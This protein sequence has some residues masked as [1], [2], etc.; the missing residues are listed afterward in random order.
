MGA[1]DLLRTSKLFFYKQHLPSTMMPKERII[2]TDIE[3]MIK[4][5]MNKD[6]SSEAVQTIWDMLYNSPVDIDGPAFDACAYCDEVSN[7]FVKA[8]KVPGAPTD[9]CNMLD[10]AVGAYLYAQQQMRVALRTAG[11]VY[12]ECKRLLNQRQ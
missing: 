11:E 3:R 7:L 8:L 9:L 2:S 12:D 1:H 5:K 10:E 4:S 6:D